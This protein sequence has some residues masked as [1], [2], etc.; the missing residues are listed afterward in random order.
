MDGS[1]DASSGSSS[2][3]GS[4]SG[5]AVPRARARLSDEG[6]YAK[7]MRCAGGREFDMDSMHVGIVGRFLVSRD[8]V[9]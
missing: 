7:A 4:G 6:P 2:G 1:S 8:T 9:T 3:S 5:A